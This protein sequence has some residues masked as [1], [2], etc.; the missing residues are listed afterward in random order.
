MSIKIEQVA[1]A[2]LIV[3]DFDEKLTMSKIKNILLGQKHLKITSAKNPFNIEYKGKQL[4][5]CVKNITYLGNPHLHH[6]KRIQ[7]PKEWKSKLQQNNT[8][9]LGVYSYK[10]HITFCLFDTTKYKHNQLNN[11]SAHVHTMDLYQARKLGIF[12]KIDKQG[13]NITV[14]TE[15]NFQKVFN[16]ILFNKQMYLS[17]ELDIFNE[18]SQVLHTDWNGIDCYKEMIKNNFNHAYQAEWAGFY[19]EYKFEE[20]LNK[21][22]CYGK[23]CQYKQ[24][25]T[26]N[27]IDLDLW[28]D[29]KQYFGDLKAHTIDTSVLGNDK[30]TVEKAIKNFKKIWYVVFS[31]RTVKDKNKKGMT[32]KFWNQ[33]LNNRDNG[34]K[35]KLNSY[36][37]RM[38][39]SVELND[40]VVLEINNFNQKYLS[41][42]KQGKN[43]NNNSRNTKISIKKSR[44][45]K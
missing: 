15:Q 12:K 36:L 33:A 22:P 37:S 30:K 38:K 14:F 32:T 27:S 7:I 8:L 11:S 31:H 13:N 23:Y 26:N 4:L 20:F 9:L 6:K 42:F 1:K 24:N 28:F 3:S 29:D 34:K 40:F 17:N 45:R 16:M 44:H 39:Y 35:K 21:N 25:K 2:G 10:N 19:L 18:F 5:L 41:D 43:S